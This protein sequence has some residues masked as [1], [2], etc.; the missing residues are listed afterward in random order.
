V[1]AAT[2]GTASATST[3]PTWAG[4]AYQFVKQ[5]FPQIVKE[6]MVIDARYNGGGFVI[7]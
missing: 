1:A 7:S 5:Y 2:N 3:F 4:R 6:G